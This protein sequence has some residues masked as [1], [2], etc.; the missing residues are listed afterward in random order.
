MVT[1]GSYIE[2]YVMI[3]GRVEIEPGHA[4]IL[5]VIARPFLLDT[6]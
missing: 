1:F 6:C 5:I 3:N 2:L 4:W